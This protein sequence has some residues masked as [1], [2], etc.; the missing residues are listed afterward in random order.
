MLADFGM[1][2]RPVSTGAGDD[3]TRW[4]R[5]SGCKRPIAF[6]ADYWVCNVSTCNRKSNAFVFCSVECW[7]GHLGVVRHRE[8]WAV[9]ARAPSREQWAE[10]QRSEADKSS[11]SS[12]ATPSAPSGDREAAPGA[13]AGG[14]EAA[15][16]RKRIVPT[17][18][19]STGSAKDELP[20][21]I[22]IVASKLKAYIRARSGYNTSDRVLEPL[23]RLVREICDDA[24][25]RAGRDER[26][27][28]LD[29]DFPKSLR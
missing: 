17:T 23:S 14:A 8:S 2:G 12:K 6:G 9:E 24:I 21:D 4:R 11:P 29:R 18:T 16:E 22:L 7:D 10:Q 13:S 25:E 28:V 1:G 15:R 27:T 5:C 3:A 26:K 19:R 20:R